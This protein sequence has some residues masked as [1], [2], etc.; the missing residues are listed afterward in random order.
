M[1]YKYKLTTTKS[2]DK[3][4]KKC[5]KCGYD[6]SLLD[7]VVE[8]LLLGEKLPEKTETMLLREI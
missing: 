6:I 3:D 8:T 2:F 1:A 4:L 7:E 5:K